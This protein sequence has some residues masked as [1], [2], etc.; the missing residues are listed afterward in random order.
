MNFVGSVSSLK[1]HL[2]SFQLPGDDLVPKKP[3]RQDGK[4]K[5]PNHGK[6]KALNDTWRHDNTLTMKAG[7]A[8]ADSPFH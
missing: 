2:E 7:Q 1:G 3:S 5:G 8:M 4:E 6:R